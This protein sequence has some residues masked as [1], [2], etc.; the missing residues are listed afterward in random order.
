MSGRRIRLA[1]S[2]AV[3][4]VSLA[5]LS[6]AAGGEMSAMRRPTD[7]ATAPPPIRVTMKDLHA[8]GGVPPGW[9]FLM[10]PGDATEGRKVFTS[11]E[12]YACHEV[13]GSP[14]LEDAP[15]QRA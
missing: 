13:K 4:L 5:V 2:L 10:P 6:I 14:G 9:K 7:R 15:W 12:C 8:H 1:S 11:M 3:T